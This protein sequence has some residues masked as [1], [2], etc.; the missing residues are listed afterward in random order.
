MMTEIAGSEVESFAGFCAEHLIQSVDDWE[1]KPLGLEPF[2][3]RMMGDALAYDAQ[4]WP[5]WRSVV[6]VLPRKN[7]KTALLA[8][9]ALYR[10]ITSDGSP[11]ILLA[12]SS[13]KQSG[14][15]FE[16]AASF[17]RKS[18][19]LSEALRVVE[20]PSGKILRE[21]GGGVILRMASD[22]GK[23][24]G[25]NPSL[26]ICDEL[27]QWTT[28]TL[29]RAYA[30]LTS[31]GG[32]RRAP[33]AFTITTAGEASTRLDGILGRI[34]DTALT[35]GDA[36]RE[37]GLLVAKM[38]DAKMLVYNY[39]AP[40]LDPRDTAAMKLANPASWITEEYL[41]RQ[42]ADPELSDAEV[43]QLHGCVW[44]AG[45]R[46]WLEPATIR[47]LADR[48]REV[49]DGARIVVAFDGSESRDST[50]L[51]GATVEEE[52]HVFVIAAWE[53]PAGSS[54]WRVPRRDVEK[55]LAETMARYDVVEVA[56]D[57]PGWYREIED[58]AIEYG[59]E[60]VVLFETKQPRRMGPACDEFEQAARDGAMTTDGSEI[61][62]RHMGHCV[63]VRRGGFKVIT[64][65]HPDSPRKIDA[66]VGA[67]IA[68]HRARWR[69]V[70]GEDDLV[71]MVVDLNPAVT[72]R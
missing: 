21:D 12:A 52:P 37:P 13:E 8:A 25:F 59:E 30:A 54:A 47:S 70:N 44:A 61:L 69:F 2:Q 71:A 1:G 3:I 66:A 22:P 36:T 58:W 68:Y 57:P 24:H 19:A 23:L 35:A 65:D 55:R 27:A 5:V 33:Q 72:A 41:A 6:L 4:G 50:V 63:P 56:P 42:A 39:E 38:W 64:K 43:L 20:N 17:V 26:V 18:A 28:P 31:G 15:L 62:Q 14:R 53:K 16:A 51:I 9:Y 32:A 60:R 11:E 48:E 67:V 49:E 40:T 10:L 29:R 46:T 34:L 7:G 45:D